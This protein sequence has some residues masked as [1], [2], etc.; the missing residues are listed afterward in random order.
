MACWHVRPTDARRVSGILPASSLTK[1]VKFIIIVIYLMD[2]VA[3]DRR[4]AMK[5]TESTYEA[6]RRDIFNAA[7]KPNELITERQIAEKYQVSKLTAGEVLH[8]LCAEGHLTSYPRS[9]YMVTMLTPRE[10][11]QIKEIRYALESIALE[12]I[13]R[14]A[15]DEEI[16]GL[17]A[18]IVTNPSQEPNFMETNTRFHLALVALANNAFLLKM[19]QDLVGT[20]SR[21]EQHIPKALQDTWQ[22]EHLMILQ[23]LAQRDVEQ[24]KRCLKL[25]LDQAN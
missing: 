11:E 6:L 24:A 5:L 25:D 14:S 10:I 9:G 20:L 15:S 12:T 17:R 19:V 16:A 23:A 21:V 13:C 8:R 1:G 18:Y 2:C 22:E 3:A 4:N 7:Y